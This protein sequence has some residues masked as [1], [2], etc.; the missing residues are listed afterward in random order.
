MV[1]ARRLLTGLVVA[2]A[3]L[4]VPAAPAWAHAE[5]RSTTP[6]S[7][8]RFD[9][10][11]REVVLRFTEPV[12]ASLGA[13]R[14]WNEDADRIDTG[15]V[16]RPGGDRR[17]V[18]VPLPP[19]DDGG[20]VVTWRVVSADG[21]PIHG[22][23]TFRVGPAV[24]DDDGTAALAREMLAQDG[25]DPVTGFA[26]AV[27]RLV[28]FAGILGVVGGGLFAVFL[29]PPGRPRREGAGLLWSS[30]ALAAVGTVAAVALQGAHGAGLGISGVFDPDVFGA[31]LDTRYGSVSAARL[32]VLVALGALLLVALRRPA[33]L[34]GPGRALFAVAAVVLA[35]TPGLAGH[36]VTGDLVAL[37]V[38]ADTL[39][40]VAVAVWLGGLALL[41]VTVLRRGDAADGAPVVDRFS[42]VAAWSVV[43]TVATG[44]FQGWRQVRVVDAATATTYGRL[45]LLKVGLVVALIA[46][47]ALS[48]RWVRARA[49]RRVVAA[50]PGPGAMASRPGSPPLSALRRTV[51]VELA[52]AVAVLAVTA[53]L[54]NAPPARSALA[55]P[56]SID[57]TAGDVL[58]TVTVDPAKAG[59][60]DIHAYTLTPE[61]AVRDVEEISIALRLPREGIGSLDVPLR[62]AGPGHFAAYGFDLPIPGT[63]ELETTVRLTDVD[64]E[65]ATAT[66]VIR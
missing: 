12:E 32:G 65:R 30:W 44:S 3:L 49:A 38:A 58:V 66:V 27:A 14:V 63:W 8:A 55:R 33:G 9:E 42:T 50:S 45:L 24:G 5:L 56:A 43:V 19:L 54:V 6:P 53:L 29:R 64:Q 20:Y 46:A 10:P 60:T 21:H 59:T 25:G 11:P 36:A 18:A 37:A 26:Y 7:G 17:A 4:V 39:H 22:A 40:V 35:A 61:G 41:A 31:A 28:L 48:R 23:F 16:A 47:A 2:L 13:V 1:L 57:L 52:L 15:R 62:R 34:P 51:A